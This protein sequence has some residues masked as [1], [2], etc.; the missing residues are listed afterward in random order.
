M[1]KGNVEV[2]GTKLFESSFR[3]VNLL[4]G[5]YID[6]LHSE[7]LKKIMFIVRKYTHAKL[8]PLFCAISCIH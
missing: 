2:L 1:K 7:H 3:N 4:V 5:D 8:I 6:N